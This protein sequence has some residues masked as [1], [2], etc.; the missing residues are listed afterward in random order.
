MGHGVASE[1]S[2]PSPGR[3]WYLV[4]VLMLAYVFALIDRQL[5]SLMVEPIRASIAISD[6]QVGL[7]QGFAFAL[8]YTVFGLPLGWLA[9][10]RSRKLLLAAGV[11]VWSLAT[12]AC[13][14]ADTFID[15]FIARVFVGIGEAVL[16]P[17]AVSLIADAFPPHRRAI[18]MSTYVSAGSIGAGLAL[19]FGGVAVGLASAVAGFEAWQT[20]FL[21]LGLP[22]LIVA[23]MCLTV[24]EP[25]RREP[26]PVRA[27]VRSGEGLWSTLRD[28][29]SVLGPQI[30]GISLFS[31]MSYALL[32]WIPTFLLRTHGMP[33]TQS[34]FWFG[35]AFA[36]LGPTGAVFGGWLAKEALER[37]LRAP[38]LRV[39]ALGVGLAW[40]PYVAGTIVANPWIAIAL[41]G[42]ATSLAAI[43]SGP[44]ITA[45]QELAPAAVRGQLVAAYY[46]SLNLVGYGLG[47]V[48][49][50]WISDR[51]FPE[52]AGIG[53][54]LLFIAAVLG[55]ISA[56]LFWRAARA[57][58]RYT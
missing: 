25:V 49:A 26:P 2:W 23:A 3:A 58:M 7:L 57:R 12:A 19:L 34:G 47:P 4:A 11:A 10:R 54:A 16:A 40:I 56:L 27:A 33:V 15:L 41:F 14:F 8:F 13:G 24:I 46:F 52:Q 32:A 6:T 9:D 39:A 45:L 51:F 44:S 37:G 18:A 42:L 35:L 36:V 5:L 31:L 43:A 55:P 20:V 1:A 17:T 38:N 50:A 30:T 48:G 53:S 29:A 22:G 28:N 21:M